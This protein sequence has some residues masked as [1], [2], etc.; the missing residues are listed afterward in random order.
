MIRNFFG[1]LHTVNKH[2]FKVFILCCKCGIPFRGLVHDLSKYSPT[3]FFEGVKY[4]AKGK[5][6]PIVN[7]KKDQGYSK[8]WLHHKGRNKHHSQYWVDLEAPVKAPIIPL[9]YAIEMVCDRIAA[10]K[11]YQKKEYTNMSAY[12]YWNKTRDNEIINRKIQK[13][14]TEVFE[15]LG[16]FGEKK[17]LNK[18]YLENI[19]Y[20]YVKRDD[21]DGKKVSQKSKRKF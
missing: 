14:L 17:V 18:Q 11:I 2:R 1:H 6:S 20:K 10:A 7:A 16:A 19:Y 3:E 15:V 13:F 5:H 12:Y 9:K 8:A 21:K 4:Y